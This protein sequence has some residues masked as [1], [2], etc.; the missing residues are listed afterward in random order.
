MPTSIATEEIQIRIFRTRK[1]RRRRRVNWPATFFNAKLYWEFS[2]R[3]LQTIASP[4][5]APN[6]R[7]AQIIRQLQSFCGSTRGRRRMTRCGRGVYWIIDLDNAAWVIQSKGGRYWAGSDWADDLDCAQ[8]FE[9]KSQ[10]H[11]RARPIRKSGKRCNV[12]WRDKTY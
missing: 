7:T 2:A 5:G 12:V 6:I 1:G 3:S 4:S 9:I 8:R 10:A 11:K